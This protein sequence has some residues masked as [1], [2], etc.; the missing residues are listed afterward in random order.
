MLHR[1][2]NLTLNVTAEGAAFQEVLVFRNSGDVPNPVRTPTS[3]QRRPPSPG[4]GLGVVWVQR[5]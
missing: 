5:V 2:A 3:I 4:L 1:G